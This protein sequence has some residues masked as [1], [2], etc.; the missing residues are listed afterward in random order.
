MK[1]PKVKLTLLVVSRNSISYLKRSGCV[2]GGVA[3]FQLTY[4]LVFVS[5]SAVKV[6]GPGVPSIQNEEGVCMCVCV[7]VCEC[8][9]ECVSMV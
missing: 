9:S 2:P 4:M 8:V 7:C 6:T 3:W 1:G 5:G